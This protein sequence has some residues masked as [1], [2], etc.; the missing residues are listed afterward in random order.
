MQSTHQK[1]PPLARPVLGH[2]HRQEWAIVGT[3]CGAVK[4]LA[5]DLTQ[6]LAEWYRLGYVDADHAG[7][8]AEASQGRDPHSAMAHG[9]HLEYTDKIGYHRFEVEQKLDTF[10]YR[11]WFNDMDAVL[12]NGNHFPA[13]RQIVVIDPKKEDSLRRKLDRLTDVRL[14]LLAEG[15]KEVFPFLLDHIAESG[16]IP[17][18]RLDDTPRIA[19]WLQ[20]QLAHARPPLYGLVLAGGKSTR[21]GRDKSLIDYHGKPQR[22]HAADLLTHF[23]ERVFL[24]GRPEQTEELS[25]GNYP[26]IADSFTGLGPF[27]AILSAFRVH[28]DAAWLVVATD[29]PLLDQ[30]TLA[31]LVAKRNLSKVATAFNSPVNQFPEPLIAV[32]EPR[33]Y[34]ILLQF[35]AQGYSCPRKALINSDVE[36]V[37]AADPDALMNVNHPEELAAIMERLE[38][39]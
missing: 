29:L 15:V 23:C 34:P 18:M 35:L 7:A 33:S 24:S 25:G 22:E 38:R 6:R 12:V 5:F 31:Q 32:W 2:F 37:D 39:R 13:G 26:A 9:A 21:M 3:P 10:Q 16:N 36:L 28:P 20:E 19:E 14:L 30:T 27:G 8:D 11:W 1:H 4:K 17:V